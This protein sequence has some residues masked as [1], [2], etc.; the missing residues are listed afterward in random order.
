MVPATV[1]VALHAGA[2]GAVLPPNGPP[3]PAHLRVAEGEVNWHADNDFR[4]D[5]DPAPAD[6]PL[7]AA[8]ALVRD[9]NGQV[10]ASRRIPAAMHQV[11]HLRVPSDPGRYTAEVRFEDVFGLG[12]ASRVTL[13]FD[14]V[15]PGPSR[16]LPP[17][18]WIGGATAATLE[19]EHPVGPQPISGIRGYA[20][21][22]DREPTGSPCAGPDRCGEAETDLHSGVEGDKASLGLLPEGIHI[23]HVVAVSGSGMRSAIVGNARLKVD[24]TPPEVTLAGTPGGWAAGPIRLTARASDSLSGMDP[25]GPTGSFTAIGIDGALPTVSPGASVTSVVSGEG[26]HRVD[27]YARDAAG[28]GGEVVFHPPPFAI[29][30]IDEGS[31]LVAFSRA[32]DPHDPERIEATVTDRL[33]GPDPTRGSISVRPAGAHRQFE[34]LQTTVSG[35]RL[36]ARWNSDDYPTGSY[37]FQATGFD[38]AGNSSRSERR[39]DGARMVLANPLK[40]PTVLQFGFG[41]ERM[42]WQRCTRAAYGRRCRRQVIR[43]FEERPGIRLV[44]SGHGIGVGGRLL[45]ASGSP[46]AGLPVEVVETFDVGAGTARRTTTVQTGEDGEFQARLAPGPSRRVEAGFAG[47]RM[48]TRATGRQVRLG[49]LTALRLRVSA[50]TASV[51]GAPVLFSGQIGDREAAIPS[52]GRPIEL[53]FRLPGS[54]WG[55]FR[56]VQTDAR[57][58]FR[59]AYAFSDDDSRGVRFQFRAYAPPQPGWP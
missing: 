11:E 52:A 53:Q 44:P 8:E 16:P 28:N 40:E 56:T 25:S 17:S 7:I 23:A 2:A 26:V 49:V 29:V 24:A 46:L 48:L 33:S 19:I 1:A 14:D 41:G 39:A 54:A 37:E 13:L 9:A 59:Y 15:R 27:F 18:G 31:P 50:A 6:L 10:V 38:A 5:W 4:L 21:S 58:H 30:R 35:G 36:I 57:G 43:S 42:I 32:Q 51:G 47:D 22:V 34:P 55:E 45:S 3:P 20:V 12:P